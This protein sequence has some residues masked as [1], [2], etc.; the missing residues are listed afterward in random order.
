[1]KALKVRAKPT[2]HVEP[3]PDGIRLTLPYPPS[4]NA[5]WKPWRNRLVKTS[6]AKAYTQKVGGV[7]LVNKVR[8][9]KGELQLSVDLYRPRKIGDIDGPLKCLL[10]S[11]QGF[12]YKNDSQIA[13]L[14]VV[15]FDDKENPR[16][17]VLAQPIWKPENHVD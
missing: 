2:W 15:R 8:K 11:L 6:E 13:V 17:E 9:Y 5:Y 4:I 7:C 14:F 12:L 1:M 10:D 3:T 16:A